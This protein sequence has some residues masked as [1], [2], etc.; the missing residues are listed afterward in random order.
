MADLE[1]E[2]TKR[3]KQIKTNIATGKNITFLLYDHH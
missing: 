1:T 3:A 2:N